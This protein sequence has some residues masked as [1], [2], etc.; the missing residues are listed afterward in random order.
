MLT[1]AAHRK[2]PRYSAS[3]RRYL[4]LTRF[5]IHKTPYYELNIPFV[6]LISYIKELIKAAMKMVIYLYGQVKPSYLGWND[7]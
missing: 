5:N 6:R 4:I 2:Y 1:G 3:E 7:G